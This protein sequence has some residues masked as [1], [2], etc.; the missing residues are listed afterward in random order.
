MRTVGRP[1]D[2]LSLLLPADGDQL[3]AVIELFIRIVILGDWMPAVG[4]V[5]RATLLCETVVVKI[6][7]PLVLSHAARRRDISR[8]E[9]LF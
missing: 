8:G 9:M 5:D 4:G 1:A 3:V 2:T 7:H 6:S